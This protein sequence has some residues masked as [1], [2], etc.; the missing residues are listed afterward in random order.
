MARLVDLYAR[1]Y[2]EIPKRHTGILEED[3]DVT[4]D[5]ILL[6]LR[7]YRQS[8]RRA[9]ITGSL[10]DDDD[11]SQLQFT[12]GDSFV[13]VPESSRT[14]TPPGASVSTMM[15]RPG[16]INVKISEFQPGRALSGRSIH[17]GKMRVLANTELVAFLTSD[18]S[19]RTGPQLPQRDVGILPEE[20]YDPYDGIEDIPVEDHTGP[21]PAVPPVPSDGTIPSADMI[22]LPDSPQTVPSDNEAESVHSD[23][24]HDERARGRR[25]TV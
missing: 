22:P 9:Q 2:L 6:N 10:A 17:R 21:A 20:A 16:N 3:Y 14:R 5:G 7:I 4:A 19:R 11:D 8:N 13:L 1:F 25:N 15:D 23:N 24:E 18:L 12:N